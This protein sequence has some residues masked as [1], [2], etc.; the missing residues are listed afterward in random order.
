MSIKLGYELEIKQSQKLVMTPELIQ[1]IK[2]LQFNTQEL[3]TYIQDELLSNPVLEQVSSSDAPDYQDGANEMSA[4]NDRD[5][6][7]VDWKEY[8]KDRQY[9]DISYR[10]HIHKDP[11]RQE[12]TYEQYTTS[13]ET[14][15][16]H[17]MLQL[18]I[19]T[20]SREIIEL[21][22][23][24]IESMDDNGYLTQTV[25]EIAEA[26]GTST[27]SVSEALGLI[28]TFEP[29]GVGAADLGECLIIQMRMT[30]SLD[31]VYEHLLTEHI[32]DIAAN[33]IHQIAK[34]MDISDGELQRR[35][36]VIRML[37][38]KPGRCFSSGEDTRYVVPDIFVESEE[39][40][41]AVIVNDDNVPEL[42]VS[43]YYQSLLSEADKDSD[44]SDY[45]SGRLN[46]AV[47]L[48]KNI[49]QRKQ[50]IYNVANAVVAHQKDFF[51]YGSKS[52]KPLTLKQVADGLGVHES[53]VSRAVNGKYLQ[54]ARG[55]F[56]LKYFFSAGVS[57][58]NGGKSVSA[59]S[60]KD[61]I[62]EIVDG[63]DPRSPYSDQD[64]VAMLKEKGISISR[65]TVAK[66]RDEMHI[67]SS[68]KRKRYL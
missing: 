9:D 67:L 33:R 2:I 12:N 62:K 51:R 30:D 59:V 65:R 16:E 29:Y 38:P 68:S 58:E 31:P 60:V 14:L 25:S 45:L 39:D 17:L 11:D 1:A 13:A 61:F 10:S 47:R 49:E 20:D 48:I 3:D 42:M 21:G 66:Y 6:Q 34:H 50:T 7:D 32:D 64:M 40:D 4:Q 5:D 28:Q 19:A 43:S 56:E 44:L 8:L 15:S 22:E 24:I 63:E 36:D 53:T 26:Y 57:G 46:S 23:Y 37:E 18:D 27:E 54:C 35:V 55:V 41:F 52:L